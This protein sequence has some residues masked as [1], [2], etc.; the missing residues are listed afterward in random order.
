M[1]KDQTPHYH[2]FPSSGSEGTDRLVFETLAQ[3]RYIHQAVASSAGQY[4]K[5]LESQGWTDRVAELM[6][7]EFYR[8]AILSLMG[9]QQ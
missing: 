1:S 2:Y 6:A 4:R 5:Y 9:E 3:H 7:A 8:V